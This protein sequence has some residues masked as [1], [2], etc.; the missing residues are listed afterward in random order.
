MSHT[1]T[2]QARLDCIARTGECG[3][4][5]SHALESMGWRCGIKWDQPEVIKALGKPT[6]PRP[7]FEEPARPKAVKS[8]SCEDCGVQVR[9]MTR[10]MVTCKPCKANRKIERARQQK[11]EKQDLRDAEVRAYGGI[12]SAEVMSR[13]QIGLNTLNWWRKRPNPIP[14]H[15]I[16]SK[17]FYRVAEVDAWLAEHEPL[18]RAG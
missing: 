12:D 9:W 7:T 13:Y 14:F 3:R 5:C 2:K 11:Q 8:W 17:A 15:I 18:R 6:E 4:S 16:G 1:P 10:P